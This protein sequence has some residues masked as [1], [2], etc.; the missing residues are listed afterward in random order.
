MKTNKG[1]IWFLCCLKTAIT[2]IEVC[3]SF[4]CIC[5]FGFGAA[6]LVVL[7]LFVVGFSTLVVM[8]KTS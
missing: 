1:R 8:Q 4:C 2:L 5:W 3:F 7:A 6:V